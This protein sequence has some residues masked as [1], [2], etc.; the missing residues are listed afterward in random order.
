MDDPKDDRGV[1]ETRE[2]RELLQEIRR[3]NQWLR[4][5]L[6]VFGAALALLLLLQ[7]DDIAGFLGEMLKIALVVAIVLAILLT[8]PFW[9][10][11]V[12]YLT[13]RIPWWNRR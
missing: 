2:I 11:A 3:Q 12:V 8:A 4:R 10:K 13:D 5:Y 6:F 9:S 1:P 7:F